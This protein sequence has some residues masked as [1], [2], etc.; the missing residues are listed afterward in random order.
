MTYH[1]KLG[2]AYAKLKADY[3]GIHNT[4]IEFKEGRNVFLALMS[5]ETKI[6]KAAVAHFLNEHTILKYDLRRRENKEYNR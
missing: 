4:A 3:P 2:D 5:R 6:D 1:K